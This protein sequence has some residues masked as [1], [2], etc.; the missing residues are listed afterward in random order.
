M[1][2][3]F[4]SQWARGDGDELIK[5]VESTRTLTLIHFSLTA[6][7]YY[8]RVVKERWSKSTSLLLEL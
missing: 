6:P 7:T 3:P 8:N 5:L 1:S 2:G 4:A